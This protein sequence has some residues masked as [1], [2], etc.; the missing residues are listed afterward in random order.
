M[1]RGRDDMHQSMRIIVNVHSKFR[2]DCQQQ[3]IERTIF[4]QLIHF[5]LSTLIV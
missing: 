3:K 1:L 4:E 5:S 2:I